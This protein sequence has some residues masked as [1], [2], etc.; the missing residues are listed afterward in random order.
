MYIVYKAFDDN[1]S[2]VLDVATFDRK[3]FTEQNLINFVNS[4]NDVLG[5]SVSGHRLVYLNAYNCLTF[6]TE[7]EA[8]SYIK[9]NGL[10]YKNKRVLPSYVCVFEKTN[11]K[12]HV[13][14]YVC[15]YAGDNVTYVGEKGYTP[16]L[17][18]AKSF[19]KKTAGER[20]ALMTKKSTTGKYWTT[21]R[22]V[23]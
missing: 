14:Y 21:L 15:T 5:A 8:D 11:H 19:D 1:T 6:P 2:V 18:A 17:Q 7:S 13:D 22:V 12:D 20:A 16:Y 9:A 23:R 3:E 4:G 10:S